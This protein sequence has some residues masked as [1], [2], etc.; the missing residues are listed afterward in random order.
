MSG[1]NDQV[2][3]GDFDHEFQAFLF[4]LGTQYSSHLLYHALAHRRF[5]LKLHFPRFDLRQIEEI[6][7]Q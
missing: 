3:R 2:R 4:R 5:Q 7:D 1:L 6:V